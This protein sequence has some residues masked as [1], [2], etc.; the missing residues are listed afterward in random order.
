MAHPVVPRPDGNSKGQEVYI[1]T[2]KSTKEKLRTN[3]NKSNKGVML[4]V[5]ESV[6]GS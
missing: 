2:M 6:G 1:C 4:E 5:V 3:S